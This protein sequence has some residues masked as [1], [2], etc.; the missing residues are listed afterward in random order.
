MYSYRPHLLP[1]RRRPT[2]EVQRNV[3]I[4]IGKFKYVSLRDFV[5][6]NDSLHFPL[7]IT[8]VKS[9]STMH[10]FYT[11]TMLSSYTFA[12][13]YMFITGTKKTIV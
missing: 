8:R 4:S 7:E 9:L 11:A 12:E 10:A 6:T 13:P 5:Y 3:T 2:P 1:L